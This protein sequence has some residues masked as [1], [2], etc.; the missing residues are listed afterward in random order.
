MTQLARFDP[1]EEL[2]LLRNRINRIMPRFNFFE[3]EEEVFETAWAPIA[4]VI[5]TNNALLIKVEVPGMTDKDVTVE[6]EGNVLTIRGERKVE[7]D[8]KEKDFRRAERAYGA[9]TRTFALPNNID[10]DKITATTNNGL[11]EIEIP[12]KES[13]KPKTIRIEPRKKIAAAA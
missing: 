3:P 12:K 4:D 8:V 1:F 9:F 5:E 6:L 7:T 13:A 10:L 2:S 11:L